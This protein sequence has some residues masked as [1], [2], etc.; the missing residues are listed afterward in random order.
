MLAFYVKKFATA[1][2]RVTSTSFSFRA[3]VFRAFFGVFVVALFFFISRVFWWPTFVGKKNL[4]HSS[5]LFVL[6]KMAAKEKGQ[7]LIFMYTVVAYSTA[8]L[9]FKANI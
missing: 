7:V 3:V 2:Y 8:V 5:V 4:L 6:R 1:V 9:A